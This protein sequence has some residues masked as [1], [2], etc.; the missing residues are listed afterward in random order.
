MSIKNKGKR[1]LPPTHPGA[2]LSEDFMPDYGLSV[3]TLASG[4]WTCGRRKEN[5]K[6]I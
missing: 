2:M 3:T 1:L 6:R 4:Q 5:W